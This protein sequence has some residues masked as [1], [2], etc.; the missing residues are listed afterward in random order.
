MKKLKRIFI[1]YFLRAKKVFKVFTLKMFIF[2]RFKLKLKPN[3]LS[4]ILN[5]IGIGII[6]NVF[7][8]IGT[9]NKIDYI[10][11]GFIAFFAIILLILSSIEKE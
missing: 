6:A 5:G 3:I 9:E 10:R 8:V 1:K 7:F 2:L 4:T 11:L